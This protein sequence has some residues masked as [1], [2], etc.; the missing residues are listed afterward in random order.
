MPRGDSPGLG[1]CYDVTIKRARVTVRA[2]V[3]LLSDLVRQPARATSEAGRQRVR[4]LALA[5]RVELA[6]TMNARTDRYRMAVAAS[7]GVVRLEA[8]DILD[9]AV[10]VAREVPGVRRVV[11]RIAPVSTAA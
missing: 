11:M 1:I 9:E 5:S 6:L 3:K 4:D 7:H 2:A 8:T 10:E